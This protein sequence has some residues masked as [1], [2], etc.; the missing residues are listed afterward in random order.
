MPWK[1]LAI[2]VAARLTDAGPDKQLHVFVWLVVLAGL[3]VVAAI[4]YH[5]VEFPARRAL[6]RMAARRNARTKL[7]ETAQPAI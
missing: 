6:R 3:P 7:I 2:N 4:S 1:R 5:L